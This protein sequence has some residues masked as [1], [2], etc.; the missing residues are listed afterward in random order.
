MQRGISLDERIIEASVK[1]AENFPYETKTSY[2]RDVEKGGR[3]EGDLFGGAI[4]RLGQEL[5]VA[6]PVT[7]KLYSDIEA[8]LKAR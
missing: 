3:N 1:K 7:E 2:Q 4:V 6:T 5:G 8:R